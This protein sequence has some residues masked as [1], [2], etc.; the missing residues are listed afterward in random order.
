MKEP[1]GRY[2]AS[3]PKLQ[4]GIESYAE[5]VKGRGAVKDVD[6]SIQEVGAAFT[7]EPTAESVAFVVARAGTSPNC[8]DLLRWANAR[9]GKMQRLTAVEMIESL[10]RSPI[11]KVLKRELRDHYSASASGD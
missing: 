10:P 3:L 4:A 8:A 2:V 6:G 5:K 9:V 1:F 11:G 7:P